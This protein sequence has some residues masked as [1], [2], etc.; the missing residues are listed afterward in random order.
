MLK[1]DDP[2]NYRHPTN[3]HPGQA[4]S[5]LVPTAGTWQ[6]ARIRLQRGRLAATVVPEVLV[7]SG[8]APGGEVTPARDLGDA[9][10]WVPLS[11]DGSGKSVSSVVI[12]A[13]PWG[14]AR[15]ERKLTEWK[16][17]FR[18]RAVVPT[19]VE[20]AGPGERT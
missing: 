8:P 19:V 14:K 3:A 2:R 10:D 12:T 7:T 15:L 6:R 13:G 11:E 4:N 17:L 18:A 9:G 16:A 20:G 5:R 1:S